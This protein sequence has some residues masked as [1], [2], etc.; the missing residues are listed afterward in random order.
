MHT[1]LMLRAL[2]VGRNARMADAHITRGE[3]TPS[4]CGERCGLALENRDPG[5]MVDAMGMRTLQ[6]TTSIAFAQ[7]GET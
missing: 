3:H 5:M 2:H 7:P 4:R 1:L 6:C